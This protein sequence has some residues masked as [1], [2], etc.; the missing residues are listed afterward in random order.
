MQQVEMGTWVLPGRTCR[1]LLGTV[2]LPWQCQGLC[3]H[4]NPRQQ[5][6]RSD[7]CICVYV[8]L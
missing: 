7:G 1:C 6:T 8:Q 5:V 2:A 3:R 4:S